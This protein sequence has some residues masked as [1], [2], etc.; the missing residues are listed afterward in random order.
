MKKEE[1]IFLD[2]GDG[3]G[4]VLSRL[5]KTKA[6]QV[7]VHI[8]RASALSASV[9]DFHMIQKTAKGLEKSVIVES[10]DGHI[11]EL[12]AL[13]RLQA[14]NPLFR[15]RERAVSDIV[16]RL[17][18]ADRPAQPAKAAQAREKDESGRFGAM[19][20]R[21]VERKAQ[22]ELPPD[23]GEPPRGGTRRWWETEREKKGEKGKA[24][25]SRRTLIIAISALIALSGCGGAAWRWLP[26]ATVV[27]TLKAETVSIQETVS[28]AQNITQPDASQSVI[29][30]PAELLVAT[31]NAEQSFATSQKERI[32][33]KARGTLAVYNAF[34]SEPQV[35]VVMTRFQSP[36]GRIFR[37]DSRVTVPGARIEN[38]R[39]TPSSIAVLVTADEAGEMYNV[40]ASKE[41]HIPGFEGTPKYDGFSAEAPRPITG[42][43]RGERAAPT[44]EEVAQAR[45][46]TAGVLE[47]ALMGE[48]AVLLRND[49][50]ALE[51]ADRFTVRDERVIADAR[52]AARFSFFMEGERR[53]IVFDEKMLRTLIFDK[54]AST[55]RGSFRVRSVD[56]AYENVKAD[57]EKGVAVF[58]VRGSVVFEPA[59]DVQTFTES[60]LG[61]DETQ[62][63][64]AIFALWGVERVNVSLQPFWV[65]RV[66]RDTSR[67]SVTAK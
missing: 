8:P 6:E 61:K 55:L 56:L 67:V 32:A 52:D 2:F 28:A 25:F 62:L 64:A 17:R 63:R 30:L 46:E 18:A 39:I 24:R 22:E 15:V 44:S 31:K 66:P 11:L 27:L 42:G 3:V 10:V 65:S 38:G 13:A 4:E 47:K 9:D 37:L 29:S 1:K 16:P 26:R 40:P 49:L 5:R 58:E 60:I 36:E 57:L 7:V 19:G 45:A 33:T 50:L 14:F 34:G 41:W 43:V 12:A 59:V 53:Q 51:G 21:N 48:M 20:Q 23:S 54:A 35:L